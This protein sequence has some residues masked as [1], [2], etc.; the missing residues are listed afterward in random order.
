MADPTTTSCTNPDHAS[1]I[2]TVGE[3]T[4]LIGQLLA[5]IQVLEGKL[6]VAQEAAHR[7]AVTQSPPAQAPNLATLDTGASYVDQQEFSPSALS[8]YEARKAQAQGRPCNYGSKCKREQCWYEHPGSSSAGNSKPNTPTANQSQPTGNSTKRIKQQCKNGINCTRKQCWFEH[9]SDWVP[10]NN[11]APE[12][13]P[14]Q[15]SSTETPVAEAG[16][17]GANEDSSGWGATVSSDWNPPVDDTWGPSTQADNGWGNP[18]ETSWNTHADNRHKSPVN[19]SRSASVNMSREGSVSN[20][21]TSKSQGRGRKARGKGR[22]ADSESIATESTPM[23]PSPLATTS[24]SADV[25][26]IPVWTAPLPSAGPTDETPSY[27]E[28]NTL[29]EMGT[30]PLDPSVPSLSS[31]PE[32]P[33]TPKVSWSDEPT[34]DI[35][36]FP[37]PPPNLGE[38]QPSIPEGDNMGIAEDQNLSAFVDTS[39]NLDQSAPSDLYSSW[40]VAGTGASDWGLDPTEFP[41]PTPPPENKT[42]GKKSKS[43]GK[44]KET[45]QTGAAN[46]DTRSNSS[47]FAAQ[48]ETSTPP[49]N[50]SNEPEPEPEPTPKPTPIPPQ[51][52]PQDQIPDWLLG[53]DEDAHAALGIPRTVS[54]SPGASP[55][56]PR[57]AP[58]NP[59]PRPPLSKLAGE[60][61]PALSG[62]LSAVKASQAKDDTP[63]KPTFSPRPVGWK[64]TRPSDTSSSSG[65]SGK[66]SKSNNNSTK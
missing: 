43:K 54:P 12:L 49:A 14:Q 18:T 40:G 29:D 64:I 55:A 6:E 63:P 27:D 36:Y 20:S 1:L 62:I 59:A 13:Q 45:S 17:W 66:G 46:R 22:R 24:M 33:A 28:T 52:V 31:E 38:P 16:N 25:E 4:R 57:L 7:P 51:G 34:I 48:S 42:T 56:P 60:N 30:P 32:A 9:P 65:K 58:T 53:G 15:E 23:S 26:S 47:N 21:S 37:D 10:P 5:K 39:V 35:V 3:Q 61:F 19:N 41:D 44:Q 11:A 8:A 2:A 50:Y